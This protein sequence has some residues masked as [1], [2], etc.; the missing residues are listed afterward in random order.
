MYTSVNL[1][2]NTRFFHLCIYIY[3][4]VP[5]KRVNYVHTCTRVRI[6][7]SSNK[8]NNTRREDRRVQC[9]AVSVYGGLAHTPL[10]PHPAGRC[11][12]NRLIKSFLFRFRRH[13]SQRVIE[14]YH[15]LRQHGDN[16]SRNAYENGVR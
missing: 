2:S 7:I 15:F 5:K 4:V 14:N 13:W 11:R 3:I 16:N 6:Y 12:S 1:V 9:A 8:V 10:T